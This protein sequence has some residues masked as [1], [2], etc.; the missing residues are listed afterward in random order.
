VYLAR[1]KGLIDFFCCDDYHYENMKYYV[2]EKR[3][4]MK[5]KEELKDQKWK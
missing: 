2:L 4:Y 5:S 3:K 1:A